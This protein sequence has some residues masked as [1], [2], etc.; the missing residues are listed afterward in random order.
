M[1]TLLTLALLANV[2]TSSALPSKHDGGSG[3]SSS[4]LSSGHSKPPHG[5]HHQHH[6]HGHHGH[7]PYH[8]ESEHDTDGSST[9]KSRSVIGS[10][11]QTE[12][13]STSE[14]ASGA[15]PS[16][17]TV[18]DVI[19][20]GAGATGI[21]AA[22]LAAEAGKKTLL[23][24]TGGPSLYRDGARIQSPAWKGTEYA[25]HDL[26]GFTGMSLSA[27]EWFQENEWC[28][29]VPGDGAYAA[30]CILGGATAVNAQQQLHRE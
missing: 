1:N 27:G 23:L 2:L 21:I 6:H 13:A 11:A 5:E 28:K 18:W 20:V 9:I 14:G 10:T 16:D 30:P 25:L 4:A 22:T 12:S 19:V 15:S 3:K 24:D 8:G 26:A 29:K 7:H 17:E